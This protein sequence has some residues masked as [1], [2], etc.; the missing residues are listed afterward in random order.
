MSKNC[1]EA[2][3]SIIEGLS[4][5]I[6]TEKPCKIVKI[7]SQYCVD[8]EYYDHNQAEI[9]CKVPVKHLQ[10]GNAYIF[11]GLQIG[12]RGT[13]RFFD[14]DTSDYYYACR[15]RIFRKHN[16]ND[17]L[18]SCG[19]YPAREQ[20]VFPQGDVVIGTKSGAVVN[21]TNGN[22]SIMGGNINIAAS[23]IS[24]GENTTID[25]KVFL[26]HTHSNGNNGSP[27]GGVL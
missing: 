15:S 11:L 19:F 2:L 23:C 20:Y 1:K 17:N 7:H 22:I 4:T 21:L 14:T 24:L 26:E 25:G 27:T 5:E 8:I 9:L 13:V 6:L 3:N 12:D 10:T 16:I 18:F